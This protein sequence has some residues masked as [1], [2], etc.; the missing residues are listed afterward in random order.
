MEQTLW[1][2]LPSSM[3]VMSC[4]TVKEIEPTAECTSL[5]IVSAEKRLMEEK[6]SLQGE[7]TETAAIKLGL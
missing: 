5:F 6:R 3:A 4:V 7:K 2:V 1:I